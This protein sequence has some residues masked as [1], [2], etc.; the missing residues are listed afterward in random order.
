MFLL[1][2]F[3]DEK[4]DGQGLRGSVI[5][6]AAFSLHSQSYGHVSAPFLSLINFCLNLIILW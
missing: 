1:Q 4:N 6:M 5:G 2:F 3:Q